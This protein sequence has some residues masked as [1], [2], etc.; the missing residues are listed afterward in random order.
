MNM[1]KL[2]DFDDLKNQGALVFEESDIHATNHRLDIDLRT[3][4]V[5]AHITEPYLAELFRVYGTELGYDPEQISNMRSNDTRRLKEGQISYKLY[6][7][8]LYGVLKI[9]VL[10]TTTKYM[11][12]DGKICTLEYNNQEK[13]ITRETKDDD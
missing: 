5:N 3:I 6:A 10:H 12:S 9:K 8:V 2:K 7:K 11:T 13:T 4:F 1:E